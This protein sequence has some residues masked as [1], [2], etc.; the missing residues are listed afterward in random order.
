MKAVIRGIDP[1]LAVQ[2]GD[3][4]RPGK[5]PPVLPDLNPAPCFNIQGYPRAVDHFFDPD[6]PRLPRSACCNQVDRRGTLRI[7]YR[8]DPNGI[9]LQLKQFT[10][11]FLKENTAPARHGMTHPAGSGDRTVPGLVAGQARLRKKAPL[12][13]WCCPEFPPDWP[14]AGRHGGWITPSKGTIT[15]TVCSTMIVLTP[16]KPV[17]RSY[18]PAASRVNLKGPHAL[19]CIF[20]P[21]FLQCSPAIP[22]RAEEGSPT[23]PYFKDDAGTG[24]EQSP[25][26][27]PVDSLS[28]RYSR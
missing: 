1:D 11:P 8:N 18:V 19:P 9:M 14:G 22:E 28:R 7:P 26:Y 21:I 15:R 10:Y 20:S 23:Y 27:Y 2:A 16:W 25:G 6:I 13:C 24:V 3:S 4:F 5:Y 12:Q 17:G